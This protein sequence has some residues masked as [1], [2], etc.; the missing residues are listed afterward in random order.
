MLRKC[1]RQASIKC[2]IYQYHIYIFEVFTS[3]MRPWRVKTR[4]EMYKCFSLLDIPW[5]NIINIRQRWASKSQ[6]CKLMRKFLLNTAQLCLKI[7]LNVVFLCE[8]LL[9]TNFNW[10]FICYICK[11]KSYVFADLRKFQVRKSQICKGS[12]LR[13]V[14]KSNK[15]CKSANLRICDLRNLFADRFA[16]RVAIF[17]F[18]RYHIL[19]QLKKIQILGHRALF[20]KQNIDSATFKKY[21]FFE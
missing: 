18:F 12:H 9:W 19:Q 15:L 7:V 2:R 8:F 4:Y 16:I 13:K 14:R 21:K 3:V 5:H 20:L 1:M 6:V 11:E 17:Y 10:S